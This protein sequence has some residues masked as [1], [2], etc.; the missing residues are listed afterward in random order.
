MSD[1][2]K[3]L[4]ATTE[5]MACTASVDMTLWDKHSNA[6]LEASDKIEELRKDASAAWAMCASISA[7]NEKLRAAL[8]ELVG[9]ASRVNMRTGTEFYTAWRAAYDITKGATIEDY[10]TVRA[11]ALMEPQ[12]E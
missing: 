7:E 11:A 3:L 9:A 6:C 4:R 2:A 10:S 12:N 5:Q 1:I 8:S